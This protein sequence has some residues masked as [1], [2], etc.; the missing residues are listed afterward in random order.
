VASREE[1]S[2]IDLLLC[3]LE[4]IVSLGHKAN[5]SVHLILAGIVE[6]D[7]L[8]SVTGVALALQ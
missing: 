7:V 3:E 6:D 2:K 1:L 4:G 8:L 5:M